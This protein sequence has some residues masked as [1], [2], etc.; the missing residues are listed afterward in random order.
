[1]SIQGL[2]EGPR[3]RA[4]QA[5]VNELQSSPAFASKRIV[6][7]WRVYDGKSSTGDPTT[8]S[9]PCVQLQMIG[10][11]VRRLAVT[12]MRGRATYAVE[13]RPIV[14]V[15]FWTSGSSQA[16]AQDLGDLIV[17]TL[18][19]PDPDL[20]RALDDRLRA[21]GI[22]DVHQ[23]TDLLP[24]SIEAFDKAWIASI[25]TFTLTLHLAS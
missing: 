20:R 8:D 13:A 24:A 18:F 21:V 25:G 7:S 17:A 22:V 14:V 16:D 11:P 12:P 9:M 2:P 5:F 6:K 23:A 1:M 4:F 15:Q 19:P 3:R 10:G